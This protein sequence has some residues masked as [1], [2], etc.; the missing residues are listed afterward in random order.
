MVT[1][2]RELRTK[3]CLIDGWRT[4]NPNNKNYTWTNGRSY[5]RIDKI[6]VTQKIHDTAVDWEITNAPGIETDH[7]MISM[8]VTNPQ[9]PHIGKGRWT[10]PEIVLKN[11]KFKKATIERGKKLISDIE[12]I[13]VRSETENVQVLFEKFKEETMTDARETAKIEIPKLKKRIEDMKKDLKQIL[14]AKNKSEESIIADAGVL[15]KK[16]TSLENLRHAAIRMATKIRDK[17]EGE[18][19]SKYWS[20]VNAERKPRDVLFGLHK[21][22]TEP[23]EYV[24]DTDKM[25]EIA[26]KYHHDLLKDRIPPEEPERQEYINKNLRNISKDQKLP[27]ADK[28]RLA[29]QISYNEVATALKKSDNN[30]SAG[31]NGIL[32]EFWKIMHG[33]HCKSKKLTPLEKT[34]DAVGVLTAVYNDIKTNGV[35]TGSNF[36]TGWMCPL[37]KKKDKRNIANYRPITL[38]N[39]DYK[40]FT[41]ALASKLSIVVH[42]IIHKAQAG[43]IPGRSIFDQVR[44]TSLMLRYAEAT[45]ENG[46]IIA[47]DQEKAYDKI[48]H[49]YLWATMRKYNIPESLIKTVKELYESAETHIMINGTLSDTFEVNR[50]VRQGDPLSCLLFDIAIEPLANVMRKSDKLRGYE[51]PG[52]EEKL[53]ATLFADDTTVY[54][55]E[56]DKFSDLEEILESWCKASGARFNVDK[57]EIIPCGTEEHRV[58][59]LTERTHNPNFPKLAE[60]MRIAKEGEATRTLGGWV[61]NKVNEI[62]VW[63]KTIDK[64]NKNL[65]RWKKGHPTIKGKKHIIQMIIGGMTQYLTT[66]Q[67]MPKEIERNLEKTLKDFIWDDKRSAI[68][69]K[70]LTLPIEKGGHGILDIPIRNEAINLIW[71]KSYMTINENRPIWAFVADVLIQRSIPKT[72]K[73]HIDPR[74]A[75]NPF[76]QKWKPALHE[77]NRVTESLRKMIKTAIKHN[78]NIDAIRVSE[79]AK[80]NIPVW[81]HL[82]SEQHPTG[83][84]RRQAAECLKTNH[85]LR[86]ISDAVKITKRLRDNAP[87]HTHRPRSNCACKYCKADK[88][89]GCKNPNTCCQIAQGILDRLKK[90]WRPLDAPQA[91]N[92]TLTKARHEKNVSALSENDFITFNPSIQQNEDL[93]HIV[94][95]FTDPNTICADPAYRKNR[96]NIPLDPTTTVYTDGSCLNGGTQNA[97]TG[98][99]VWF[100]PNDPKNAAIR[101]PGQNHSNQIGEVVGALRAIQKTPAFSPL[102]LLSDSMYVI[103][104]LTMFLAKWEECG[105]I[106]VAN[107]EIFKAIVALLRERGA[108]TR[109]K[110]VK[111]HSGILG[112]EEAD[113]LAGEGALKEIPSELDLK[114]KN[115]FNLTGAQ[116]SKMTQAIAYQGIK[117]TEKQPK[118]RSGTESR[119]DITRYTAEEM[120]GQTPLNETI[121]STIQHKDLSRPIRSFFWKATHNAHKIG[122]YWD[123][124]TNLEHRAWCHECTQKEGQPVTESLDHILLECCE[125]E[126]KIIWKLAEQ[127][128]KKKMPVWPEL[129]NAGSIVASSMAMFKL[130]DGKILAGANRLYRILISESAY[131]IWKLRNKRLFDPKPN[132]EFTKPT[133]NEIHN[134][135]IRAINDR[136]TLDIAMSHDKYETN[137]IPRRKILQTWRRTLQNEKKPTIRLDKTKRGCSG[138]RANG[139]NPQC[140]KYEHC[141]NVM[142]FAKNPTLSA[143]RQMYLRIFLAA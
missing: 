67:G 42:K 64:I 44:L 21:P 73:K 33:E 9:M 96:G 135:W 56:G 15:E 103:K 88:N 62:S 120:F 10:L 105:Y 36:A 49:D 141:G 13:R 19:I 3:L 7:K 14:N 122:D 2:L 90:K 98:S 58:R 99:R 115:K 31:I 32:Y 8:Q 23:A 71:T 75:Q 101:V 107:K 46:M 52:V 109:F 130:E 40:I 87:D 74:L 41:K 91:D 66:V 116:L 140:S 61:G 20:N 77:K 45:K 134:K 136:L 132:E 26:R 131:L 83:L 6:Y 11:K 125:P 1:P 55:S 24:T 123:K 25:A 43:F 27:S 79:R 81:Y 110:W 22:N 68:N 129:R 121:W 104:A 76:L 16:I 60:N 127:L 47:L 142:T 138:Y 114:I 137:A 128:W 100:G 30:T 95:V 28:E 37:Y 51:I 85:N 139:T 111:G 12:N 39:T 78:I 48:R 54:L 94:R 35:A 112:N 106:G 70:T 69:L 84:H 117:E 89:H 50:G 65:T 143:T 86:L 82:G 119:L 53:I 38:L 4:T 17:I 92:L 63:S 133:P 102:D 93:S 57:T 59:M 5:S 29:E 108:P 113:K 97:G 18:T 34:F 80:M 126:G 118:P 124:C 72:G